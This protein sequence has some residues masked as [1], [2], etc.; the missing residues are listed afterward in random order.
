MNIPVLFVL[1]R[2]DPMQSDHLKRGIA[3]LASGDYDTAI[4]YLSSATQSQM[5]FRDLA[6]LYLVKAYEAKGDDAKAAE[7]SLAPSIYRSFSGGTLIRLDTAYNE[8]MRE[9]AAESHVALLDGAA[10]LEEHPGVFV[11]FCHFNPDGHR[12]LG[13]LLADRISEILAIGNE[14]H[15]APALNS[16]DV[17]G[18]AL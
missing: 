2:D 12:R 6:R 15:A 3:S 17:V 10:V 7:V 5:M 9:V 14:R 13:E 18:G 4:A 8:I 16:P 1:L 11:D